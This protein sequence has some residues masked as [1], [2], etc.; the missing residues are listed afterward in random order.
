[1]ILSLLTQDSI[2]IIS[3][4]GTYDLSD[5]DL[6]DIALNV[7][8]TKPT[9]GILNFNNI[10]GFTLNENS[11]TNL[12]LVIDHKQLNPGDRVQG[13]LKQNW[14]VGKGVDST[15]TI[16]SISNHY[17]HIKTVPG[18]L[19][20]Y[21]NNS[22]DVMNKYLL[23]SGEN[24]KEIV[25]LKLSA[26]GE[27]LIVQN[28]NLS[29]FYEYGFTDANFQPNSAL[30]INENANLGTYDAGIDT[31]LYDTKSVNNGIIPFVTSFTISKNSSKNLIA[32]VDYNSIL[33]GYS[34]VPYIATN[35]IKAKGQFSSFTNIFN[36]TNIT[37]IHKE[38]KGTIFVSGI[39]QGDYALKYLTREP[40][41]NKEIFSIR[42]SAGLK[43]NIVVNSIKISLNYFDGATDSD[44]TNA[45]LFIDR[46]IIGTYETGIDTKLLGIINKPISGIL[47]F[48]SIKPFTLNELSATNLLLIISH[49]QMSSG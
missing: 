46:G 19:K 26:I 39:T 5:I 27:P 11:K 40:E 9:N 29:I 34:F 17:A 43:E 24:L 18:I 12:L 7:S 16:T 42:I 10:S 20:V 31:P 6:S 36:K 1:M 14:I 41:T 25:A 47:N 21:H 45:K 28:I 33:N 32:L 30:L 8:Q 4:K 3:I 22:G 13:I 38:A 15:L 2:L 49:K 23:L 48:N 44:F 35:K 37:G